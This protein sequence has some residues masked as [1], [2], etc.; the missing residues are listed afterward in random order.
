MDP[1]FHWVL[2][3]GL[4]LILGISGL[5]KLRNPIGFRQSLANYRLL[6][7]FLEKAATFL[8]PLLELGGAIL[9][10]S[11]A[12]SVGLALFLLLMVLFS[13]AILWGLRQGGGFNCGCLEGVEEPLSPG[14]LLRNALLTG[15]ALLGYLQ[16]ESR[17]LGGVD[18]FTVL[19]GSMFLFLA[20]LALSLSLANRVRIGSLRG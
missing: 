15:L 7:Q 4:A 8:I 2:R 19:A 20:Y 1:V 5:S 9:I 17:P 18:I 12:Y 16:P 10:L 13:G 14:L 6:P 3:I 11:P